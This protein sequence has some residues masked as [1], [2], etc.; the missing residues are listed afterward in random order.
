MPKNSPCFSSTHFMQYSQV[1]PGRKSISHTGSSQPRGPHQCLRCLQS[2]NISK[3]RSRGAL[4]SR[5]STSTLSPSLRWI[6]LP[7]A[8][9]TFL[10]V[11]LRFVGLLIRCEPVQVALQLLVAFFHRPRER[12]RPVIQRLEPVTLQPA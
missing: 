6:I 10:L 8:I 7:S 4:N 5:S 1:P 12:T 11:A 9:S 3:T 2:A